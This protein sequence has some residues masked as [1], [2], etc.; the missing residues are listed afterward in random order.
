MIELLNSGWII[1]ATIFVLVASCYFLY[2]ISGELE[3][4]GAILGSM[5]KLPDVIVAS[6][7]LALATSGPEII[8]AILS[9]SDYIKGSE[10]EM[11]QLGEKACSGTLNMAFSA[12]DNLLG[13]GCV[14][15]CFMIWKGQV[16][17][18]DVVPIKAG[19]IMGLFFY[20]ISSA[21]LS[22][23]ISDGVLSYR[24]SWILA[25]IAIA[26]SL[27]Q[28]ASPI[29]TSYLTGLLNLE[30]ENPEEEDFAWSVKKGTY[31][32]SLITQLGIYCILMYGLIVFVKVCMG[33]TF[34]LATLQIV[35]VG[36]IL[37]AITSYVS[38]FPEFMIAFRYALN[39]KTDAIL[40]MLF[41]S[42]IIDLGFA[43]FRSIWLHQDMQVYTTGKMPELL[44]FYIWALPIVATMLLF[45]FLLK[46]FRWGHAKPLVVFYCFYII[47]GFILL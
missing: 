14:G 37:L 33:A 32:R 12:M 29:Y 24:E 45:S 25:W 23:S 34:N 22:Y 7:F 21:F 5:L 19:T 35:S 11:L 39:N 13:I 17:A 41:G 8:M 42:N 1:F 20:I 28:L 46:K 4:V 9:A 30:D 40:A 10:W 2:S 26:F 43:G 16:K 15:I 27:V 47:S 36:G 18:N 31:F 3:K 6:T 44:K 38:S